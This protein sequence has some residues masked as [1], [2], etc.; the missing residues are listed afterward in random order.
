MIFHCRKSDREKNER[1]F[2]LC[3]VR[4]LG[5]YETKTVVICFWRASLY[6]LTGGWLKIGLGISY[7][8]GN[9]LNHRLELGR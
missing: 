5:V 3:G 9:K 1:S 6:Q 2:R 4:L 7:I 8:L